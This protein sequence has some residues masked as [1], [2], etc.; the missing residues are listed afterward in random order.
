MVLNPRKRTKIEEIFSQN[1]YAAKYSQVV[2]ICLKGL[3]AL[4]AICAY[5]RLDRVAFLTLDEQPLSAV[6]T[7][8]AEESRLAALRA[9]NHKPKPTYIASRPTGFY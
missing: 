2:S 6:L 1:L 8:V 9:I 5:R 3:S 7:V 4:D